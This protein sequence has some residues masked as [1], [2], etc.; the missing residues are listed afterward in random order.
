MDADQK[1]EI[2]FEAAEIKACCATVYQS[3]VA[4]FLLGTSFH[5]G[6]TQ[7]T[8]YLGSLLH[9]GA[10]HQV[11]DI[12]SGQGQSAITLAQRFGCHVLGIE[13]S[14]DAVQQATEAARKSGLDHLVTFQEGDAEALPLADNGFDAVI[15][16]CAFC[17]FP[18]KATA[19][20]EFFRVLKPGG[21][22]GLSDLTRVGAIPPE[23]Q[24]L[25]AWIAC[26]ADA[27]PLDAYTRYLTQAGLTVDLV[28]AHDEA[29]QAMV[30][31]IRGKLLGAELLVRLN[32][33]TLPPS[34]D[35]EQART[36]ARAASTAIELR[37]FGYAILLAHKL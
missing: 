4:R 37:Q 31:E 35:L 17:T 16:E 28:E 27:Q 34:L 24:G 32:K 20:A 14:A 1:P 5:P 9:L 33:L 11:L 15:C 22:L 12:A 29:L 19:A 8:E 30:Q 25:L 23:L 26:I 2:G 10:Q 6:G 3:D 18:D 13:Y 21:Q 36:L 7:L